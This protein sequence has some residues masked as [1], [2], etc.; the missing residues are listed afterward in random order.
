MKDEVIFNHRSF[1]KIKSK[2]PKGFKEVISS[3]E[4]INIIVQNCWEFN[5]YDKVLLVTKRI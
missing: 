1:H 4:K 5:R 2:K 3:F